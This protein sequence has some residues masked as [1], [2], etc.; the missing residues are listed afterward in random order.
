MYTGKQQN[1]CRR[2][3]NKPNCGPYSVHRRK[4]A[5]TL[6]FPMVAEQLTVHDTPVTGPKT[7]SSRYRRD[8]ISPGGIKHKKKT[9]GRQDKSKNNR[10]R[11]GKRATS[12]NKQPTAMSE[13]EIQAKASDDEVQPEVHDDGDDSS[14]D[15]K[16]NDTVCNQIR[17]RQPAMLL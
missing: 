12:A 10:G 7:R 9:Y 1:Y 4:T 8:S 14:E 13:A 2:I 17:I 3:K 11:S 16:D 6:E 5:K 15:E